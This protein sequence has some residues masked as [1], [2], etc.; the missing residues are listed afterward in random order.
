MFK[1]Y[2]TDP[3]NNQPHAHDVESLTEALRHTEGFRKLGMSFVTMVSEDPRSVG[4]PGVDS[5]VDGKTPDGEKYDWNK[6]D[7]IGKMKRSER[8]PVSTDN[9]IVDLNDPH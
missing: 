1:I 2:Y 3:L 7:R 9:L 4:K 6:A 5:I 8:A